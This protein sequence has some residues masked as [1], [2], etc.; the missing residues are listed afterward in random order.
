VSFFCVFWVSI[1]YSIYF[2]ADLQPRISIIIYESSSA[3]QNINSL[4][5]YALAEDVE[6]EIEIIKKK[7][8]NAAIAGELLKYGEW[9]LNCFFIFTAKIVYLS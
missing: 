1:V 3:I 2:T 4:I 9:K 8:T 6:K 5:L 7:T